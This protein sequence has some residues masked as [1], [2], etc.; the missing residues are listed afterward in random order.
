MLNPVVHAFDQLFVQ[1]INYSDDDSAA[2]QKHV[3][4]FIHELHGLSYSEENLPWLNRDRHLIV[5]S[6][7]RG[8]HINPLKHVHLLICLNGESSKVTARGKGSSYI[9]RINEGAER[10]GDMI[11]EQRE[12]NSSAISNNFRREFELFPDAKNVSLSAEGGATY[13][14]KG[15][16]WVF[17]VIPSFFINQPK[18]E[19]SFYLVPNQHDNWQPIYP[20]Q[21]TAAVQAINH[22][23]NG[24]MYD[25]IHIMKY[26]NREHD[27]P[28]IPS[29][30]L[31]ALVVNYCEAKPEKLTEFADLDISGLLRSIREHIQK[32]VMDPI[33]QRGDLNSLAEESRQAIMDQAFKDQLKADSARQFELNRDYK[34]SIEK[35]S[36]V[37]GYEFRKLARVK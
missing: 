5:S 37:V 25:L 24:F 21:E 4:S 35:W 23:H 31:E 12:L 1:H 29:P 26:W 13:R 11:N 9:I 3:D 36:E 8:T 10:F 14:R 33:G 32:P 22:Q 15:S 30:L 28:K 20:H 17:N 19:K 6:F 2:V 7:G 18:T 16:L 34:R 27:I